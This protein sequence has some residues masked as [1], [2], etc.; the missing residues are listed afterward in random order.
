MP[1]AARLTRSGPWSASTRPPSSWSAKRASPCPRGPARSSATTT[2]TSATGSPARVSPSHPGS[3]HDL[4]IR[5]AG[6]PLPKHTRGYADSA[7]QGYD[8]D[9][10]DLDI[11]YK[12]PKGGELTAEETDYNRGL[13]GFRDR[14]STRLNSSHANISYAVFCL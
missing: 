3:E 14:K 2:S 6:P 7:Y 8:K 11:P 12:K 4:T 10:P 9:H 13:S 5:R 1:A